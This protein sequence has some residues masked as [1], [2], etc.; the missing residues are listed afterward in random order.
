MPIPHRAG[1]PLRA[2][3]LTV[4]PALLLLSAPA[5]GA[6]DTADAADA[7]AVDPQPTYAEYFAGLLAAE[8][9]GT[10]VVVDGA[11][12]GAVPPEEMERGLHEAFEP[13]GVPYH[14]VVTPYL[15]VGSDAGMGEIMPAVHDRL[16]ADGVYA[17]LPAT[18]GLTE[19]RV[20]GADLSV[21]GAWDAVHD[22]E[23]HD[24]PAHEAAR[25][26]VAGL[27]GAEPPAE[28]AERDDG[29][30]FLAGFRA[31]ID[32]T[33]YNGPENLGFLVGTVGGALLVGAGWIAWR[34]ARRGR[35]LVPAVVVLAA[36]SATG[37]LVT[38][39]YTHTVNAPVGGHE[40]ADPEEL[41]R[42]EPPYVV[43]TGRVEHIAAALAE[44]PLYVD[45][46]MPLT[47]EG[48]EDVPA[49]LTG[50]PVPVFAAAVPLHHEDEAGGD[51]EVLAAAL[52]SVAEEDGVY[53]VVGPGVDTPHVGA[54]ARGLE[55][56]SYALWFPMTFNEEPTPA[57]ALETAV[58][59]LSEL[60]FPPGD[61]YRPLFADDEANLPGPRAERY[62]S[63]GFFGGL[64]LA[65]PL[66]AAAVV[67]AYHLAVFLLALSRN[68]VPGV[69]LNDR[70]LRRL[71]VREADRVRA[72]VE[73]EP[74]RI[75]GE[76]MPQ[77]E[78]ALMVMDRDPR[79]LDL[80]GAAVLSRRVLAAVQ[81][82]DT[83]TV[84]CTVDPLHPFAAEQ[85]KSRRLGGRVPLC[86]ECARLDDSAR[87]GRVLR[88][89]TGGT[90]HSYRAKPE[91]PWIRH[92]F[93]AHL[94]RRLVDQ[95]FEENRV[96]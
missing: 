65:G 50:A 53:L 36:L 56:D 6:A 38:A 62:W 69:A 61:G 40:V 85:V 12:G 54:A 96:H 73:K 84:P 11:I 31:D 91:D 3:L 68:R 26:L 52:A 55:V 75:P 14:V 51:P 94:P 19:L 22:A 66:A 20:Y 83:D 46:I 4:A 41:V 18:G 7:P 86:A 48:L 13:L 78:A 37:A 76:F 39:T 92:S 87:A 80:L 72:L 32:P 81:D 88:L 44:D 64:F 90:A 35:L 9:E 23:L 17:V 93:G 30:G 82:P 2:L 42:L 71:A 27:T 58:A 45:P 21:D 1:G 95:L 70:A 16:G 89:R 43:S 67:A 25:V 49:L 63:G 59:D 34:R 8:P 5:P 47:R 10:A 77:A 60:E 33:R 29:D 57:A 74:D 15:G 79:G 24:V 28:F